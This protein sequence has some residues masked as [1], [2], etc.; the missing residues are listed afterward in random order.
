MRCAGEQA[1]TL[2][3]QLMAVARQQATEAVKLS[4]ND[5]VKN[6]HGRLRRLIAENIEL[7]CD[8]DPKVGKVSM[9]PAQMPQIIV[10]LALRLT[11]PYARD[12]MPEGGR[13]IVSTR[14]TDSGDAIEFAVTETGCGM[15]EQTRLH[16]TEPFFT[17]KLPGK[18][19]GMGLA[20]VRRIAEEPSAGSKMRKACEL[21]KEVRTKL[22]AN[23]LGEG[24]LDMHKL[25]SRA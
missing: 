3:E 20:K 14:N 6:L 13:V 11:S 16:A 12:A 8:L 4:W 1:A 15:D 19:N 22:G 5:A 24:R 18:G 23:A 2:V 21:A 10:N 25:A 17:T 9:R 7:V